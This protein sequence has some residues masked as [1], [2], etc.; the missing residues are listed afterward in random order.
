MRVL[1]AAAMRGT[2]ERA[3][4]QLGIP[5]LV[6]ME[7]AA[8]GVVEALGDRFPKAER[9]AILCGPGNNGGDG[10]AVARHLFV[11]GY[12]PAVWVVHGGKRLSPDAAAQLGFC[13]GL[14]IEVAEIADE[15]EL[16]AALAEAAGAELIVDALF[17]TGLDRPLEGIFATAVDGLASLHDRG[18][19]VLAVDLPS[20]LDAGTHRVNGPH[21]R[22]NLTVTFAALKVAHVLPPA[23]LACG[24]VAVADLGLPAS[25]L[26]DTPARLHLL[27]AEEI[28]GLLPPRDAAS[29]KGTFGRLLLVAGAPGITGAA[30]LA[31][32]AAVRAGAGLTTVA[33]PAPVVPIVAAGSI[34]SM[35]LPVAADE[36]GRLRPAAVD[37][38]LQA[39]ERATALAVGPGLGTGGETPDA[40]RR[41]VRES[42]LPLV[43]DADGLNA[44]AGRP[45]E[46]RLR[47]AP[48][49]LTP[50]PVELGRLLGTTASEID[51]DRVAAAREAARVTGAVVVLKGHLT[52]IA[53]PGSG[54]SS[55]GTVAINPTGNA[56]M[57]SGGSGDVLTGTI[58]A[59]L[60]QGLPAW[61]AACLGAYAHGLAGDLRAA[62]RGPE[63][64]AAGDLAASLPDALAALRRAAGG[65]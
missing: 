35:T 41:L 21:A 2:D 28:G 17:G 65:R 12:Q 31:A 3:I 15:A 49:V 51:D 19:P 55:D 62:E 13:H 27:V 9:V 24:I 8:I 7:N 14:G 64:I 4:Q 38:V 59:L 29:H 22:A 46:L 26:D 53:A 11:R 58:G 54:G 48:T 40:I 36:E 50:H 25:F 63:A 57:A 16:L 45:E 32:R 47:S 5:S 39:A 42:T 23:S 1:S 44:F 18:L 56:G 6:L 37:E 10:L 52:L 33:A 30:V 34:E 61:D 60:A 43:L 20:G